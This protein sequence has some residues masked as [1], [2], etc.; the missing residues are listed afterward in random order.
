VINALG[1]GPEALAPL[2]VN[3]LEAAVLPAYPQIAKIRSDLLCAGALA[4]RMTGSGSA[5]FGLARNESHA[6]RM[7]R[8]LIAVHPW[9]RLVSAGSPGVEMM[10]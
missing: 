10:K 5:V 8:M 6:R 1:S 7:A 9:V 3:D 2:L 4:A